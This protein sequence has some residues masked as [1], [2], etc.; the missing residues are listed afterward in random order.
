MPFT[1]QCAIMTFFST[2][3]FGPENTNR[4]RSLALNVVNL[5]VTRRDVF[6]AARDGVPRSCYPCFGAT[7]TGASQF[8]HCFFH[9]STCC[10][11]SYLA[12]ISRALA[13][14]GA[15]TPQRRN[16]DHATHRVS[17]FVPRRFHAERS[18]MIFWCDSCPPV[19]FPLL[20]FLLMG[21]CLVIDAYSLPWMHP[22]AREI[23]IQF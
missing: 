19:L 5:T 12:C 23:R 10:I 3:V 4:T 18:T 15:I 7:C 2:D 16:K 11:P 17:I 1:P 8:Q 13:Y 14:L 6:H 20:A 21:L 9:L 22:S